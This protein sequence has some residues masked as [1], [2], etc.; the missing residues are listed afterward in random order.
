MLGNHAI[1]AKNVLN[2]P[3]R[4][5]GNT[6][7]LAPIEGFVYLLHEV[8]HVMQWYRSPF[9]LIFQYL[10]AIVKSVAISDGHIPW[11]HEVIDFE[12]E[13]ITFQQRLRFYLEQQS[14]TE[15]FLAKFRNYR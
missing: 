11:A 13:A 3:G 10:K 7:D 8:Y 15:D 14:W 6:F 1:W 9:G 2:A 12:V 4:H 5:L